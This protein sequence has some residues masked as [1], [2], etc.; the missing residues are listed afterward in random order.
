MTDMIAASGGHGVGAKAAAWKSACVAIVSVQGDAVVA[1][2]KADPCPAGGWCQ[3]AVA[4]RSAN[5]PHGLKYHVIAQ[6]CLGLTFAHHSLEVSQ[7]AGTSLAAPLLCIS[8]CGWYWHGD[9]CD[10]PIDARPVEQ[11]EL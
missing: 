1:V 8:G 7:T 9:S 3:A 6:N 11:L 5:G 10:A 4:H 2:V